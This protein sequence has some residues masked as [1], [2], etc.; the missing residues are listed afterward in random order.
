MRRFSERN[1]IPL[2]EIMAFG[3]MDNDI[4]M[5]ETAG[6]GVCLANGCDKAK[7]IADAITE[8]PVLEDGVGRYLETYVL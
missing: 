8:Y 1:N 6:W 5:L 3:D 7:A 2:N 4:A